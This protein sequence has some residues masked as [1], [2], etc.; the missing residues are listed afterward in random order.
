MKLAALTEDLSQYQNQI[1]DRP[2]NI[3][4]ILVRAKKKGVSPA[5]LLGLLDFAKSQGLVNNATYSYEKKKLERSTA[6]MRKQTHRRSFKE[7]GQSDTIKCISCKQEKPIH[8]AEMLDPNR[9][10]AWQ[11][12]DCLR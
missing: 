11:C 7:L 4:Y 6:R 10:S 2:N 9:P 12:R 1:I 3:E 8:G 5:D